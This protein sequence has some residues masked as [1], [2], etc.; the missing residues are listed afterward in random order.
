MEAPTAEPT[1]GP[2]TEEQARAYINDGPF[3]ADVG[4][5]C[6]NCLHRF[7]AR[8]SA[9]GEVFWDY[10]GWYWCTVSKE[11]ALIHSMGSGSALTLLA[12]NNDAA[13][14]Y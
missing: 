7:R 6:S 14:R 8:I 1:A 4:I 9:G 2:C 3:F 5:D 12:I 13:L 10:P 11:E